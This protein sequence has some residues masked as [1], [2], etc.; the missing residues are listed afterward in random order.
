L[1]PEARG[2]TLPTTFSVAWKWLLT[3]FGLASILLIA[4][5]GWPGEAL[6]APWTA[7]P[8]EG[9]FR[10]HCRQPSAHLQIFILMPIQSSPAGMRC[11]WGLFFSSVV[12]LYKAG[13]IGTNGV[14][15][16]QHFESQLLS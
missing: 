1:D 12:L 4:N 16:T 15:K 14:L 2:H 10:G 8:T 11:F 6:D 7:R 13:F 5:K 3:W 9:G